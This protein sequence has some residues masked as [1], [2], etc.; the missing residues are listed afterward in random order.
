MYAFQHWRS[1]ASAET[2]VGTVLVKTILED[3]DWVQGRSD[4][5]GVYR[6][7]MIHDWWRNTANNKIRQPY[8]LLKTEE[9]DNYEIV[10]M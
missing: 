9:E 4:V 1:N 8:S 5:G 2:H 3:V 10:K 7:I 6:Y